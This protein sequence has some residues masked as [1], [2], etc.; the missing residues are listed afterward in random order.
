MNRI[1]VVEDDPDLSQ[2]IRE[3]LKAEQLEGVPVFD[4]LL[5]HRMLGR[6][7]FDCVIMDVN[8]PGWDGFRLCREFRQLNQHTPVIMLTAF[9]EL[10]DK[11]MGYEAGADDYLAKPFY[12][13]ELVL[14]IQALLKRSAVS[15]EA[16]AGFSPLLVSG[17]LKVDLRKKTVVQDGQ[18]INLTP[19]EFQVLVRLLQAKGNVVSKKEFVLEIWGSAFDLASATNT[20]EVYINFLRNKLDKPFGKSSVRTK[21]GFGYYYRAEDEH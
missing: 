16:Q 11:V 14:K 3:S 4:G 10:E 6:E 19:R 15:A 5:A 9:S 13:K 20:I 12:M 7:E 18:E 21:V 8:L 2:N 17:G 1:L